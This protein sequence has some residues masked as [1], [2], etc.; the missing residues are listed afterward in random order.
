MRAAAAAGGVHNLVRLERGDQ[1]G[2]QLILG[3][4]QAQA[5]PG[6]AAPREQFAAG[7][8]G[9]AVVAAARHTHDEARVHHELGDERRAD[10]RSERKQGITP[11]L[12]AK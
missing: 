7:G 1:R 9:G 4:A 11:S 10:A 8:N 3:V 5:A 6:P 2:R 12:N